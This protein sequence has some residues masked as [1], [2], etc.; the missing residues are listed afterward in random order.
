[1]A[2]KLKKK[3]INPLE[4]R[5]T[6]K[7]QK[8]VINPEWSDSAEAIAE[9]EELKKRLMA[10]P[11]TSHYEVE[12]AFPEDYGKELPEEGAWIRVNR[13]PNC[14]FTVPP[15]SMWRASR[16][17]LDP[18]STGLQF[19]RVK[20]IT[21]KGNLGIWP[22]EYCIVKDITEWL[23]HEHVYM[24]MIGEGAESGINPDQLFYIRSRGVSRRE[25]ERMLFTQVTSQAYC[26]FET[27][28]AYAQI[29]GL[30]WPTPKQCPYAMLDFKGIIEP[31]KIGTLVKSKVI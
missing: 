21:P 18:D 19:K 8:Y 11:W 24:R 28:P 1:M 26:W 31:V 29:Y 9:K 6:G 10:F 5:D 20:I 22:H 2:R 17:F 4:Q 13:P 30:P 16:W 23:G 15:F 3:I 7:I 25:A 14:E 27:H 12:N